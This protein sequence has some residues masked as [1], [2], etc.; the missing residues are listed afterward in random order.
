MENKKTDLNEELENDTTDKILELF[1]TLIEGEKSSE[2][3]RSKISMAADNIFYDLFGEIKKENKPGIQK[4]DIDKFMKR[5]GYDIKDYEIEIIMEKMDKNKD[6][7][8]DYEEF[9][10][11][12]QSKIF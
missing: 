7:T 2:E 3:I 6:G 1:E 11:E 9:I 5:N 12:V 10:S 8:I 4:D